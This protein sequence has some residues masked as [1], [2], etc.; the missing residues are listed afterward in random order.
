[1]H[2]RPRVATGSPVLAFLI[3]GLLALQLLAKQRSNFIEGDRAS[4]RG[5]SCCSRIVLKAVRVADRS[6]ALR[7]L[8]LDGERGSEEIK[9]AFRR[10]VRRLHPDKKGGSD[11]DFRQVLEAYALLT[12][13]VDSSSSLGSTNEAPWAQWR[14]TSPPREESKWKWSQE[15]GFRDSDLE[16][17]WDD[18]GYNPYTGEYHAPKQKVDSEESAT[19]WSADQEEEAA[20]W[21]THP[22]NKQAAAPRYTSWTERQEARCVQKKRAQPM[23]SA[24]A[25]AEGIE[26]VRWQI[27][28]HSVFT[29]ACA[30]YAVG[31]VGS[32]ELPPADSAG[33]SESEPLRTYQQIYST[34]AT[35]AARSDVGRVQ[36][37][38]YSADSLPASLKGEAYRPEDGLRD[39]IRQRINSGAYSDDREIFL[40]VEQMVHEKLR[41]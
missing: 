37:A 39:D 5:P 28:G 36:F 25:T 27:L 16:D 30:V 12:G 21:T 9:R 19:P 35:L 2:R 20:C 38:A 32:L 34:G 31:L 23:A 3:S 18:I 10:K 13:K 11:D 22:E 1:M 26:D 4:L 40:A 24:A 8:G 17:V 15:Y 33:R 29:M 6:T 7:L 14:G 41:G